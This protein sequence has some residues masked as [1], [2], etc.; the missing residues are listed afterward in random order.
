MPTHEWTLA[1]DD[2]GRGPRRPR[3]PLRALVLGLPILLALL[4]ALHLLGVGAGTDA[5]AGPKSYNT[6]IECQ[7][8]S[9][10]SQGTVAINGT[11]TGN[12][13]TYTVTVEVLDA[14]SKQRIGL[15]TFQVEGTETFGGTTP[16]QAPIGP[17]G[18]ICKILKVT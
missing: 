4:T 12:A 9:S 10:G 18:I 17:A 2:Y 6:E 1:D 11:I 16:A 3:V 13:T 15:Q 14:A 5:S 8:N 7:V